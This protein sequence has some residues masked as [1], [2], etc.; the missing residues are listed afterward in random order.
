[1]TTIMSK[2]VMP[3]AGS[4]GIPKSNELNWQGVFAD[5]DAE[6]APTKTVALTVPADRRDNRK[7]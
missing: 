7:A 2:I 6:I 4:S 5:Y 3:G 1:M